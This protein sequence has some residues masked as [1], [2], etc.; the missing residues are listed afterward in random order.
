MVHAGGGSAGA[1]SLT[2]TRV[3]SDVNKDGRSDF[4]LEHD[5]SATVAYWQMNGADVVRTSP[6]FANPQGYT[7]IGTG[8]FNGDGAADL[9]WVHQ[10]TRHI[11]LWLSDGDGFV[12]APVGVYAA[13]WRVSGLGDI[14]GDGKS[15][16][17]LR[18][19]NNLIA[20]WI[21]DGATIVR[22]PAAITIPQ[23]LTLVAQGDFNGDRKLD[24]V[25]EA[26]ETRTLSMWLG[27]GEGFTAAP[28]REYV[29]GWKVW[30]AGDIDGD[31]RDDLLLTHPS[32]RWFAYWVMD[33]AT[34][35]RY[36]PAFRVPGP[37]SLSRRFGP[38]AV[39]DYNGDGKLDVLHS[40][41]GDRAL[42]IWFGDGNGF[43]AFPTMSHNEG[44]RI[45]RSFGTEG[46]PVRAYVHSDA[47][48]DGKADLL[49]LR[50]F[51]SFSA[52]GQQT[53]PTGES[54]YRLSDGPLRIGFDFFNLGGRPLA[55]G[56][57]DGDTRA[58]IVIE[59]HPDAQ[60]VR[61][62]VIRLSSGLPAFEVVIPTPAAGWKFIAAG[63]VDGDG[64]SDLLLGEQ[65]VLPRSEANA[66]LTENP[67]MAG[68]AY[69]VMER[70]VV[71]RY[72]VGFRVD[73]RTPRL[74]ARGDFDGDGRLDLVWSSASGSSEREM[75]QWRGDG[76]GFS[77]VGLQF[78]GR[79]I[80]G[81]AA[82][83]HVFGAGDVD[84]DGK[85]DLL[86]QQSEVA[87]SNSWTGM[88]FWKMDANVIK[89]F[90]P[91]FVMQGSDRAFSDY[92]GD[93]RLDF[94]L[95]NYSFSRQVPHSLT[96][97]L[98]DGRGFIPFQAGGIRSSG[99]LGDG[100]EMVFNR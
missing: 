92:N 28:V 90:S 17:L 85:S 41:E 99:L 15:D 79:P 75:K 16:L 47:N 52:D 72:S 10:N 48:G 57:F 6:I 74:A 59:K 38:V 94:V 69:W 66:A 8:D 91:G 67:A 58:D 60:G 87:L 82:G 80:A 98:G 42:S 70:G 44:W 89:A 100:G 3:P 51:T 12:A 26:P 30:G 46:T 11:L 45:A 32:D 20:Y 9:L 34:P 18:A 27:S 33:G 61:R 2:V 53:L 35:V 73:P 21:M 50:L 5:A 1:A 39:G 19:G 83:W 81:P 71:K 29:Q 31:G 64:R 7:R 95:T 24:F 93:G 63:D 97:W 84:G 65:T 68:F 54:Y 14:D 86:L 4:L 78:D 62:T 23:G 22:Q 96:M 37:E 88:A 36:S 13:E 56:D 40:R 25:W 55:T 77:V 43:V 49:V 76:N